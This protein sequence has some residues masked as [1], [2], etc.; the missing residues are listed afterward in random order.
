MITDG[1]R[2]HIE[3]L[4]DGDDNHREWFSERVAI[5]IYDGGLHEDD[6]L[7][8]TYRDLCRKK[9]AVPVDVQGT[10]GFDVDPTEFG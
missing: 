1:Q 3:L 5:R 9:G 4:L 2:Q 8:L 6:A 10:L 7:Y